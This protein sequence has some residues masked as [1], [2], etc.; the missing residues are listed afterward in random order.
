MPTKSCALQVP[1]WYRN[2]NL[3]DI[4]FFLM[5]TFSCKKAQISRCRLA[6]AVFCG[7]NKQ[8]IGKKVTLCQ[9]SYIKGR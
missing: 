8:E 9:H 6:M 7:M 5:P 2:E 3:K 4:D 1:C